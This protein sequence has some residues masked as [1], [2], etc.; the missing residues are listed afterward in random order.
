MK[1]AAGYALC[2]LVLTLSYANA[3]A[4]EAAA[5]QTGTVEN[6]PAEKTV[7]AKNL[8]YKTASA[9]AEAK[10][11]K[12]TAG[13][14]P[15]MSHSDTGTGIIQVTFGL[16]VVLLIIAAAAWFA[17]RFGHFQSTAGGTMRIVGGL[18]LGTRERLVVVQVGE[19]QLL[20]GVAPGRVSTLHV[21]PKP[22]TSTE[23]PAQQSQPIPGA[24]LN[25]LNAV[26]K[27]GGQ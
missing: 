15:A 24:F 21:L 25:K 23:P 2:V 22:L 6:I 11:T 3:F 4:V 1:T 5:P 17:R 9:S 12:S 10:T 26:L 13:D 20:L 14:F 18:H 19:E 16:F 7:A 27:K 8:S